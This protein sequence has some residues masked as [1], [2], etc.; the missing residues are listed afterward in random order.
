M[1]AGNGFTAT[2]EGLSTLDFDVFQSASPHPGGAVFVS[3]FSR[4][5]RR[6]FY[7]SVA[8]ARSGQALS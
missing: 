1:N 3:S 5:G 8:A 4:K 7:H 2:T 6:K